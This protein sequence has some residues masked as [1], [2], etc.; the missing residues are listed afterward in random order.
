MDEWS[1]A[2]KR[3]ALQVLTGVDAKAPRDKY[4]V[5]KHEDYLQ[6][7]RSGGAA[8]EDSYLGGGRITDFGV[9]RRS[10]AEVESAIRDSKYLRFKLEEA[11]AF[12]QGRETAAIAAAE[13]GWRVLVKGAL[14]PALKWAL[15]VSGSD[16][17]RWNE[18][19]IPVDPSDRDPNAPMRYATRKP[20]FPEPKTGP[21]KSSDEKPP[22]VKLKR[23]LKGVLSMSKMGMLTQGLSRPGSSSTKK[24]QRAVLEGEPPASRPDTADGGGGSRPTS[25]SSSGSRS[26]APNS[27]SGKRDG[28]K[29][30]KREKGGDM[31]TADNESD[32]DDEF[33]G[34]EEEYGELDEHGNIVNVD[35][36]E[37]RREARQKKLE[38]QRLHDSQVVLGMPQEEGDPGYS[39]EDLA[40]SDLFS[41]AV[42]SDPL[43]LDPLKGEH[44]IKPTT[45]LQLGKDR[46]VGSRRLDICQRPL[47]ASAAEAKPMSYEEED[48]RT[49]WIET[50]YVKKSERDVARLHDRMIPQNARREERRVLTTAQMEMRRQENLREERQKDERGW[51][52]ANEAVGKGGAA[53]GR[54]GDK[55][56][57]KQINRKNGQI[58]TAPKQQS[59]NASEEIEGTQVTSSEQGVLVPDNIYMT[60]HLREGLFHTSSSPSSNSLSSSSS[61]SSSLPSS[62]STSPSS[63]DVHGAQMPEKNVPVRLSL[64][65]VLYR[66]IKKV[67]VMSR[68]MP[69]T[70]FLY[71]DVTVCIRVRELL[72]LVY[73]PITCRF[74]PTFYAAKSRQL[75]LSQFREMNSEAISIQIAVMLGELVIVDDPTKA[76][77]AVVCAFSD[78]LI[79][80]IDA[81]AGDGTD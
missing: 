76:T 69:G 16:R 67:S 56:Q 46:Y 13:E 63:Y 44:R 36:E 17:G 58:K 47:A 18:P 49:P 73:E 66:G 60:E 5:L 71:V 51:S 77:N 20:H 74:F 75:L 31:K 4:K 48:L 1:E 79:A 62:S 40:H 10:V 14:L 50:V 30:G 64:D 6:W 39:A 12:S 59:E 23:A 52:A 33:L 53:G 42:F 8:D 54:K 22:R 29:K 38:K 2:D 72:F 24:E 11:V 27:R 41:P 3:S 7:V 70:E 28:K 37:L 15:P 32:D 34:D 45:V 25:S 43:P 80:D 65:C 55:K 9:E 81:A 61:V 19:E 21:P 26:S 78:S 57:K 68:Q 35:K